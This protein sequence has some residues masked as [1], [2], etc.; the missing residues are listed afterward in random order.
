MSASKIE[1]VQTK[2]NDLQ[3]KQL[4]G[5]LLRLRLARVLVRAHLRVAPRLVVGLLVRLVQKPGDH[6]ID[7]LLHPRI[8]REGMGRTGGNGLSRIKSRD[9]TPPLRHDLARLD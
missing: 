2:T 8:Y 7:H 6:V 5:D 9:G 3:T 1:T 4:C